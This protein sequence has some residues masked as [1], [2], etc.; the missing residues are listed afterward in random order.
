LVVIGISL[1]LWVIAAVWARLVMC[2]VQGDMAGHPESSLQRR[3]IPHLGEV[4]PTERV[5][6][7]H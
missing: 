3:V 4:D 6:G 7:T 2:G 5:R 1:L